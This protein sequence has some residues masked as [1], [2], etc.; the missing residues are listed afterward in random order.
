MTHRYAALCLLLAALAPN[1]AAGREVR[2]RKIVVDTT[3]RSEGVATGDVN[4][5]GKTDI[6]AGDVWFEAPDWK[7]HPI[8]PVKTYKPKGGYSQCFQNFAQ[9]VD[10]D[11]WVDSIVVNFPGR[12]CVWYQNPQN[13]PG[14]WKER[15]V[16]PSACGET[17]LFADLLGTGKPVLVFGIQPEGR[18]AWF[19]PPEDLDAPHWQMHPISKPKSHSTQRFTHGYGVGDVDGDGRNDFLCTRGWWQQP[20]DPG[21]APWPFRPAKLGPACADMVVYDV[22]GDGDNDVITSSAHNY[23]MWWFEHVR[24]DKG[25]AF[26]QH[27]F[28]KEYSQTHALILADMD[29]DGV[30]DLV[31]GKRH[32]AHQGKDPGGEEPAMVFWFRLRR[33]DGRPQ[34]QLHEI[35]DDSGVGTQFEVS[36]FDGDGKLDI[37][38][39]NKKGVHLFLQE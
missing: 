14:H 3:F 26:K 36:D 23:G 13:K 24:G 33:E 30:K 19:T 39:S 5:D 8:R 37:I 15:V 16:W 11:G 27:P 7:P 12:K 32:Y 38:T 1:L 22:D 10:G 29:G 21:Q 9:D 20:Q 2:F 25:I 35:D 31:S 28:F 34:F 18:I 6:F 17:P 4:H